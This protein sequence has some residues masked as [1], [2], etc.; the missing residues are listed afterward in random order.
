MKFIFYLPG[1]NTLLIFFHKWQTLWLILQERQRPILKLIFYLPE[2]QILAYF[3]WTLMTNTLTYFLHARGQ[4]SSLF[5]TC[6]WQT[7]Y[8]N[9]HSPV[10]HP[11]AC[12]D[13]HSSLF[14]FI[15]D[16][17]SSLFCLNIN[18]Q[19][20]S[21]FYT[22]FLFISNKH[23]SLFLKNTIFTCLGQTL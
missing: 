17:H 14:L 22:L 11:Q 18:D 23:T 6:H 5:F 12:R 8:L 9:L 13:Q 15:S 19:H 2:T 21:L 16:K 7:L 1:T 10:T 4:H 20:P 3:A